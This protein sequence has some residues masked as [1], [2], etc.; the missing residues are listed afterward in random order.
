MRGV[1]CLFGIVLFGWYFLYEGIYYGCVNIL[2]FKGYI[3]VDSFKEIKLYLYVFLKL[4]RLRIYLS[5]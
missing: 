1:V 5:L 3:S 4:I 2:F